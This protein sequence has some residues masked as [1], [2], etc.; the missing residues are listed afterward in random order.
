MI[1]G[2]LSNVD[3]ATLQGWLVQAQNAYAAYMSS[4]RVASVSYSQ[5]DGGRS[6]SY[7]TPPD[8][9]QLKAWISHLERTI[10]RATGQCYRS[11]RRAIGVRF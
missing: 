2:D 1:V 4:G 10:A 6:V 8:P 3:L 5:G 11:G 9:V 7:S